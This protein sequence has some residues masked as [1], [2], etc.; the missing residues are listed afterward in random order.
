M[1]KKILFTI[2]TLTGGGG[3][4]RILANIVNNLSEN[5]YSID[6]LE[7]VYLG[8]RDEE[9]RPEVK[10]LPFIIDNSKKERKKYIK[11]NIIDKIVWLFP[12]F[13][14]RLRVK[15]DYDIEIA[16]NYLISSFLISPNTLSYCWV[17]TSIEDID[18]TK[19]NGVK[20]LKTKFR[21]K[22]QERSFRKFKNIVAISNKTEES[23]KKLYPQ[24]SDKVIKI[25]N[26][27][28][29]DYIIKKSLEPISFEKSK[30]TIISIG[31][32]Q[33]QKNFSHLID[34]GKIISDKGYDFEM[35]ILGAGEEKDKLE[36]LISSYGLQQKVKLLGYINNPY[37]YIKAADIYCMTS[38]AEGFPTVI[39]E[40]M[41]LGCPFISTSV[42]GVDELS[43]DKK[44]GIV[45]DYNKET[46]AN[47]II[48]II[49]NREIITSMAEN[50]CR[51]AKEY[52]LNKQIRIIEKF[53]DK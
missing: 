20:R 53:L 44:C 46:M 30:F 52:S 17:H 22:L 29:I 5:K 13:I 15:E 18:Y 51:K 45:V 35:I 40:A 4:E 38:I 21:Y 47:S 32:L 19:M 34:V 1:K 37:P 10:I 43:S 12:Y 27:Y 9:I 31:R 42:A 11:N 3:A 28:D 33:E 7:Y 26:G 49:E 39:V 48:E 23:I 41:S 36:E 6:I 8:V 24:F 50:C 16:F 25:Y 14:R 2:W